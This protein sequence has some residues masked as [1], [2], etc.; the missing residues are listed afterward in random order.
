MTLEHYQTAFEPLLYGVALAIVLTLILK[1][2]GP[3][4]ATAAGPGCVREAHMT[5]RTGTGKYEQLLERC[6]TLDTGADGGR[7]PLRRDRA[8]RGDR[9]CGQRADRRRSWSAPRQR[10]ARSLPGKA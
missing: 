6:R 10:S 5:Q 7:T 3:A 1:E 4:A 9:R 8:G 2:T